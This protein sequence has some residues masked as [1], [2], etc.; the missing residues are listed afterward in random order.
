MSRIEAAVVGHE[1]IACGG[2]TWTGPDAMGDLA[3]ALIGRG[4]DPAW[5]MVL[6]R[7]G[8][9]ALTGT[10]HAFACRAWAGAE[11]DPA[12][13]TW[14]PHPKGNYPVALRAWHARTASKP[15]GAT[16]TAE[17]HQKPLAVPPTHSSAAETE[18]AP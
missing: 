18:S 12:F 2:E 3:R 1:A 11:A 8:A 14:H 17:K 16:P 9:V 5:P 15:R 13:R 6:L 4:G 10:V 7:D